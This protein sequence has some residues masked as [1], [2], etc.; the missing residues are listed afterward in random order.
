M[1]EANPTNF[2]PGAH[3]GTI[4]QPRIERLQLSM[5]L[6]DVIDQLQDHLSNLGLARGLVFGRLPEIGGRRVGRARS[7]W[8]LKAKVAR[9]EAERRATIELVAG[10]LSLAAQLAAD[11]PTDRGDRIVD[12]LIRVQRALDRFEYPGVLR[13]NHLATAGIG[14][15]EIEAAAAELDRLVSA[16]ELMAQQVVGDS[17]GDLPVK[18]TKHLT[19]KRPPAPGRQTRPVSRAQAAEW[20][21]THVRTLAGWIESGTIA[22]QQLN[23]PKGRKWVFDIDEVSEHNPDADCEPR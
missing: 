21:C 23:P 20:F 15:Q 22:A 9:L 11:S 16:L 10:A 1:T 8:E 17:G 14:Q 13:W 5:R 19:P 2:K 6:R 12:A 3:L 18:A 7:R 4:E